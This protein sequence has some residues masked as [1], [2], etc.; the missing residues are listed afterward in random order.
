MT[1]ERIDCVVIGA[2]VVGL[3]IARELAARG[4]ETLI[5][6][7]ADAIGTG[8]SARNSE[9]IHAGI[10]YPR[11]SL[12]ASLCVH[13]RDLLYDFCE[14]HNIPHKR[15]GKLIVATSAGQAKQLKAIAARAEENGVL[16]LLTLSRDE[17]QA[18]EPALECVEAL[19]S[20]GTG[21][22]DSHQLMLALLGDAER[23]GAVCVLRSPVESVDAAGGRFVVRVGASAPAEIDA[24]CVINSAGLGAQGLARRIGGLDPRWVP[25]LYLA[26]GNY[27]SLSGRA[28]FNHLVYPVPDRAGLGVHLTLDLAGHARFGPDV[29]WIDTLRYDVDP[30]RAD[31]FYAAIRTY[32]PGLPDGA[33]QPAYAGV[34]SKVAGPGEPAADFVIQGAAQHGVRGLVNLFGI[35]SPGLTASLAIAQRVG[36]MIAR[37]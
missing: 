31:A 24:A 17:V 5:V 34:R 13:G 19:F 1:M 22:V 32:W 3:A 2:G 33:L 4:R 29:E 30:R 21:I 35:E 12:K 10:Y 27:F 11:G 28:P 20:P 26:R 23:G 25:P 37:A 7:A 36:E 8:M 14:T 9:V 16:D 18:L 15:C 6:E